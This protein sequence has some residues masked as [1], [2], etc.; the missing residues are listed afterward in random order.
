MRFVHAFA[1]LTFSSIAV[2]ACGAPDGSTEPGVESS[3]AALTV[4]KACLSDSQ[5]SAGAVCDMA[6]PVIPGRVHCNIA[7]GT[8]QPRC[9]ENAPDLAGK[10]FTSADGAHS[11]TFTSTTSFTK[12]DGCSTLPNG[13]RCK[14]IQLTTGT[15]ASTGTSIEL[16][17]DLGSK[18][19]LIVDPHCYE[20]LLDKSGVELYPAD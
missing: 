3:S 11:I 13:A 16:F 5:C 6:C 18:D 10:T 20:G 8:C 14:H 7:G 2:I 4:T 17:G 15:F 9:V 12:T 19:T 1:A